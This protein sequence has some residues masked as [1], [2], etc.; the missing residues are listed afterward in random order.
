MSFGDRLLLRLRWHTEW[1]ALRLLVGLARRGDMA[2]MDRLV[3]R[4]SALAGSALFGK[5]NRW[6][7]SNLAL[8]FGDHLTPSQRHKLIR[9]TWNHIL[10]SYLEPLRLHEMTFRASGWDRVAGLL[11]NPQQ[12][13]VILCGIHLGCWEGGLYWLARQSGRPMAALYRPANNPLS[14]RE[15]H[16]IRSGYGVE[17]VSRHNS[18]AVVRVLKRGHLLSSM[19]DI[20]MRSGGIAVPF[21][22][23]PAMSPAGPARLAIQ[24]Q[25]PLVPV[26]A[27]RETPGRVMM[28]IMP[29]LY[30]PVIRDRAEEDQAIVQM[31]TALYGE[32][33]PWI[34]DFAEQYNWFHARWRSRPDGEL[35]RPDR[36]DVVTMA[37]QRVEPCYDVSDRIKKLFKQL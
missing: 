12:G 32:F 14:E 16:A 11:T 1:Y 10:L 26:V 21:L 2:A 34:V 29:P 23:V 15:F 8:I 35:W 19:V 33:K 4:V 22:G 24:Y 5:E 17:W 28:Q 36:P 25:C 18:R 30:P 13:C 6:A 27:I 31:T 7:D 9:I 3:R 37:Q 20:N